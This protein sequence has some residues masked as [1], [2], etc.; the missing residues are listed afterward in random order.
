MPIN[1]GSGAISGVYV[2]SSAVSAAYLGS[3]Q[4]LTTAATDPDFSS[5]SVLLHM[6][7]SNNGTTFTDSSGNSLAVTANGDAKTSTAQAKFGAASCYLDGTGDSLTITDSGSVL[8]HGTGDFTAEVWF[9]SADNATNIANSGTLFSGPSGSLLLRWVVTSGGGISVGKVGTGYF[10]Q[11]LTGS[12][13]AQDAWHH[14]AV[15]RD[16]TSLRVYVDGNL[17]FTDSGNTSDLSAAVNTLG[18]NQSSQS[19]P[20]TG[21][22]DDFRLTKGVC[23]YT[24][25]SITVPTAAF[26]D[27]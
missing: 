12:L 16:N 24:G 7:G 26:P 22:M 17:E 19:L 6:E 15:A 25:T 4:V 1:L 2:G 14:I 27:A 21:Y 8:T 9:Y 3:T 10:G 5:V 20:W 18:I 23:R 11:F 13:P